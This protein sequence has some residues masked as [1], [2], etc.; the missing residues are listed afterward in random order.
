LTKTGSEI[1]N[2]IASKLGSMLKVGSNRTFKKD[3][4]GEE[5]SDVFNSVQDKNEEQKLPVSP[6]VR[7]PKQAALFKKRQSI[8]HELDK[9]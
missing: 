3:S 1:T 7:D 8:L 4:D 2:K 9:I 6:R 5:E